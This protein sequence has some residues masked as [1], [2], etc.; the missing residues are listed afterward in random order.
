MT[1][2]FARSKDMKMIHY[3]FETKDQAMDWIMQ[4]LEDF[5]VKN[6]VQDETKDKSFLRYKSQLLDSLATQVTKQN[7][8]LEHCNKCPDE[9]WEGENKQFC[10]CEDRNMRVARVKRMDS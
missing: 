10:R 1:I 7:D 6:C 2:K 9:D 3:E 4:Q 8:D 5:K